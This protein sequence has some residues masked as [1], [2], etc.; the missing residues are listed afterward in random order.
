MRETLRPLLWSK[1]LLLPRI[2]DL[3]H[4]HFILAVVRAV[5]VEGL[6]V[7]VDDL[8]LRD[9]SSCLRPAPDEN[10]SA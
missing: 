9:G 8:P 7:I 6:V 3:Q 1:I 10:L 4:L 2:D 5:H